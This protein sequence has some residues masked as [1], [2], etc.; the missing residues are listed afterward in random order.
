MKAV[1]FSEPYKVELHEVESPTV[2]PDDVLTETRVTGIGGGTE[3]GIFRGVFPRIVKGGRTYPMIPGYDAIGVVRE[4]GRNVEKVKPCD[5]VIAGGTTYGIENCT[6][7]WG[8]HVEY[9]KSLESEVYKIPD[10]ITQEEATFNVLGGDAVDGI[11]NAGLKFGDTV[12]IIGQ[13]TVG[14]IMS[15]LAKVGGAG[16]VIAVD[17]FDFKLD[18]SKKLGVNYVINAGEEDP[19]ERVL[20]ITGGTGADVVLEV[21]GKGKPINQAFKMTRKEGK[22]IVFGRH[23][24]PEKIDLTSDFWY[25]KQILKGSF[26]SEAMLYRD[27]F[28][29]LVST[30]RVKVKELI[31]HEFPIE[32]VKEAYD[33]LESEKHFQ[34]IFRWK[35]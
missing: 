33:V 21:T 6:L 15:Q 2:G 1:V 12:V 26:A 22:I 19:V 27:L 30:G 3:R 29:S 5:R 14:Q 7:Y 24:K 34:I 23:L 16:R 8:G 9:K 32:K 11:K 25:K 13:G 20:E 35:R 10:G 31:T 17:V 4:V 28:F 18:M